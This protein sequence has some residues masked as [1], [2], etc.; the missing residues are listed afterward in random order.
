MTNVE[1]SFCP[2]VGDKHFPVLEGV[3]GP[4]INVQIGIELLHHNPQTTTGEEIAERRSGEAF[5]EGGN[6]TTG[7]ENVFRDRNQTLLDLILHGE[8]M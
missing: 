8:P 1:V 7:D 2:V 5:S 3:H 6:N 4:R